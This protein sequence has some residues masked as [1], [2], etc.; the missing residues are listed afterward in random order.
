MLCG[1]VPDEICGMQKVYDDEE[2]Q[3][4]TEVKPANKAL[5]DFVDSALTLHE[6][7]WHQLDILRLARQLYHA[8]PTL[9]SQPVN[10]N[11]Q[12]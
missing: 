1:L 5:Q 6:E 9:G 4:Q 11:S 2:N 10:S 7:T 3:V 8:N 12:I